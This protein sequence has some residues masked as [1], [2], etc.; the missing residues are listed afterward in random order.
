MP[1]GA[2]APYAAWCGGTA[3]AAWVEVPGDAVF[4]VRSMASSARYDAL[5]A[6]LGP[7][8]CERIRQARVLVVGAGGIGCELLKDLVLVGVGHVDI[9]RR[10]T[11]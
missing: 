9:V 10:A 5:R 3:R 7:S 6:A 11:R 2:L 8:D 1:R 4:F